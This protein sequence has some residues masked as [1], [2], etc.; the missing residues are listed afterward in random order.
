M[1]FGRKLRSGAPGD[2]P[3]SRAEH[4]ARRSWCSNRSDAGATLRFVDIYQRMIGGALSV[5]LTTG[6]GPQRGS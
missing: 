1:Q 2:G 5:Q 6:D 3:D 4:A